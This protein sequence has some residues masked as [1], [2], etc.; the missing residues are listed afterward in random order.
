MFYL[1]V[2]ALIRG[3]EMVSL[4]PDATVQEA[5]TL[6][7]A[8][9]VGA[10]PVLGFGGRLA[11]IFTERDLLNR[12]VAQD[13]RPTSVRLAQVMTPDPITIGVGASLVESLAIMLEHRFRHLPL[14]EGEQVVGILSCRDIPA[15]Y[16]MMWQNWETAQRE[17]VSAAA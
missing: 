14:L 8:R 2:G 4:N 13:L 7:A 3:Q 16:W 5:A 1:S 12:V 15:D 10:I 9:R 11:G 6:M 17:L